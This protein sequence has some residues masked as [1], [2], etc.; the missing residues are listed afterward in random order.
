MSRIRRNEIK[1][2]NSFAPTQPNR[3][4]KEKKLCKNC[5]NENNSPGFECKICKLPF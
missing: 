1:K 5:K 2:I 3:Y 4:F